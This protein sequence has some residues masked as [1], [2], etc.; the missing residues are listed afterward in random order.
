MKIYKIVIL[1]ILVVTLLSVFT[2]SVSAEVLERNAFI[3]GSQTPKTSVIKSKDSPIEVLVTL[4]D[5]Y[6]LGVP[7]LVKAQYIYRAK[8]K[9]NFGSTS[10][11]KYRVFGKV[12]GRKRMRVYDVR[13]R[14][15]QS[16]GDESADRALIDPYTGK[17]VLGFEQTYKSF[18]LR[19]NKSKTILLWVKLDQCYTWPTPELGSPQALYLSY[20]TGQVGQPSSSYPCVFAQGIRLQWRAKVQKGK[21]RSYA[22]GHF[23]LQ[24][25]PIL[26]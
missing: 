16:T 4:P 6:K 26:P 25:V 20:I 24:Y 1:M 22:E 17:S 13:S 14:Y 21:Y 5:V 12:Y 8:N 19:P 3:G 15:S 10:H 7:A 9:S 11:P 18:A 2:A 23:T